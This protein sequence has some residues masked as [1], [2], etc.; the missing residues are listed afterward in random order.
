MD[1]YFASGTA[2]SK[3]GNK[4][5]SGFEKILDILQRTNYMS[6]NIAEYAAGQ[7][8]YGGIGEAAL[9]GLTAKRRL[10]YSSLTGNAGTGLALDI[11]LDPVTWIPFGGLA[12]AGKA[13]GIAKGI[14]R[15]SDIAGKIPYL[16]PAGAKTKELFMRGFVDPL[17]RTKMLSGIDE[18]TKALRKL[19]VPDD[20]ITLASRGE[21]TAD[22]LKGVTPEV[23]S[24]LQN[25]D[26]YYKFVGWTD[27]LPR[28]LKAKAQGLVNDWLDV[29]KGYEK[30]EKAH[31]KEAK[32]FLDMMEHGLATPKGGYYGVDDEFITAIKDLGVTDMEIADIQQSIVRPMVQYATP[33]QT[34]LYHD[35][36]DTMRRVVNRP[37][38]WSTDEFLQLSQAAISKLDPSIKQVYDNALRVQHRFMDEAVAREFIVRDTIDKF[39]TDTGLA[40]IR[41][42]PLDRVPAHIKMW[43]QNGRMRLQEGMVTALKDIEKV[44]GIQFDDLDEVFKTRDYGIPGQIKPSGASDV[45]K[46]IKLIS[47]NKIDE[48]ID[49]PD[50]VSE[51]RASLT[52]HFKGNKHAA[53]INSALNRFD[54]YMTE[55][56]S[57]RKLNETANKINDIAGK[58]VFETNLATIFWKEENRLNEAIIYH[59]YLKKLI[60]ANLEFVKKIDPSVVSEIPKDFARIDDELL[61]LFHVHKDLL[62]PF[63]LTVNY[64]KGT[65]DDWTAFV[66]L[67]D[68]ITANIKYSLLIPFPKFH[69]RNIVSE[70]SFNAIAGMNPLLNP[71]ILDDYL[72]ATKEWKLAKAGK[73]SKWYM[74]AIEDG[75]IQTGFMR[76]EAATGMAG[77]WKKIPVVGQY[78]RGAESIGSLTEEMP[79][80]AM[81]RWAQK[82]GKARLDKY[83]VK[84]AGELVSRFH[85][86]Y[87]RITPFERS[88]MRRLMPFYSWYRFNIPL[89]IQMIPNA[90]GFYSTVDKT[91]K[92]I[93]EARGGEMPQ[94]WTPEYIREGYA[95]G[96]SVLP[97]KKTYA[98]MRGWYPAADINS[99][100]SV[101]NLKDQF[102]SMLHPAKIIPETIWG[103]DTYKKH[104]IPAYPGEKVKM[105][106]TKIPA[107]PAH[108]L[109]PIRIIQETNALIFGKGNKQTTFYDRVIYSI[110]G[111][112]YE[113]DEAKTKKYLKWDIERMIHDIENKGVPNAR[114]NK[115]Y[116]TVKKLQRQAE[117]LKNEVKKL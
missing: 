71:S 70:I 78:L 97:G 95:I 104:K 65:G 33:Q 52:N 84:S 13:V 45:K 11:L 34:E 40:H 17:Y 26:K 2:F 15:L 46:V 59:D 9:A 50:L 81:Y 76:S 43:Q 72:F 53:E 73:A 23:A 20:L 5:M 56:R 117:K 7:S 105:F 100:M 115:D 83:S 80:L 49:S 98:I 102:V 69:I 1:Q 85:V 116:R 103:Y 22:V 30:F 88:A 63:R 24:H 64:A 111:N 12:K 114:K 28:E 87:S 47:E 6:A 60:G 99:I 39:A 35:L 31:P 21:L 94:G 110:F 38:Q 112:M 109:E 4:P 79:R 82:G 14:D 41:H 101:G 3:G 93:T 36:G 51:F 42:I 108:L 48:I 61:G 91:R 66:K 67:T 89:H 62:E 8:P 92:A 18:A 77:T 86:D 57:F 10:T 106:G 68:K 25:I 16:G 19:N 107:R 27:A 29:N 90:P 74:Q 75:A 58:K 113:V 44:T 32:A 54:K 55:Y 96:W 37:D